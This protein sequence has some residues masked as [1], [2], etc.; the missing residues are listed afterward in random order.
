VDSAALTYLLLDD[1]VEAL[2]PGVHLGEW[3]ACSREVSDER[4]A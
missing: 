2:V 4:T 1:A 3:L